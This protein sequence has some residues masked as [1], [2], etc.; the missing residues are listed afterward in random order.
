MKTIR[1][2]LGGLCLVALGCGPGNITRVQFNDTL[3]EQSRNLVKKARA[4]HSA[5]ED[6]SGAMVL[7]ANSVKAQSDALGEA[8]VKAKSVADGLALPKSNS[9]ADY[10]DK[11]K[12][13]IQAEQ[14][15][16]DTRIKRIVEIAAAPGPAAGKAPEIEAIFK[17]IDTDEE[18]P[19]KDLHAAQAKFAEE[20]FFRL[21]MRF[22]DAGAK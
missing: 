19:L 13:F 6:T 4:L 16:Y 9:A 5:I 7:D 20:H 17:Q 18:K 14:N 12:A 22:K 8:L 2:L 10:L 1:I 15:I 3:V 11:F 21:T